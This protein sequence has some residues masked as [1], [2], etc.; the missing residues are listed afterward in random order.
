MSPSRWTCPAYASGSSAKW[1]RSMV[2]TCSSARTSWT[3]RWADRRPTVSTENL[4]RSG[5]F[6]AAH[7]TAAAATAATATG[8]GCD[9]DGADDR[10]TDDDRR[11]V[12]VH[13]FGALHLQRRHVGVGDPGV[14]ADERIVVDRGHLEL[15]LR[16]ILLRHH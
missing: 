13:S 3:S 8:R 2:A 9:R 5:G 6:S 10:D 11:L 15:L 12:D 14:L 1:R 4:R 7:S 16:T